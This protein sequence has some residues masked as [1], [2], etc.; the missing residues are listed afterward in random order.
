MQD[1]YKSEFQAQC[2]SNL[3]HLLIS[4]APLS[5]GSML[6]PYPNCTETSSSKQIIVQSSYTGQAEVQNMS[7]GSAEAE[8][9]NSSKSSDCVV[10]EVQ[11]ADGT[12]KQDVCSG[13]KNI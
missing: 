9:V 1:K 3:L 11:N 8:T 6:N 4:D 7:G 2:F 10:N 5:S 12:Y 13:I